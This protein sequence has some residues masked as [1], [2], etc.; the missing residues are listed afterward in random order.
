MRYQCYQTDKIASA[1]GT[2]VY[3]EN[4][5]DGLETTRTNKQTERGPATK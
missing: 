3:Q 1:D 2:A 4:P 5:G